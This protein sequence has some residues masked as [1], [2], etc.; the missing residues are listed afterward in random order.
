MRV[1]TRACVWM[2]VHV[3]VWVCVCECMC[4]CLGVFMCV[5]VRE[6]ERACVCVCVCYVHMFDYHKPLVLSYVPGSSASGSGAN[7]TVC[8]CLGGCMQAY[9]CLCLFRCL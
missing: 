3:C 1:R 2:G 8:E 6:R 5:C 7:W 9:I 4:L